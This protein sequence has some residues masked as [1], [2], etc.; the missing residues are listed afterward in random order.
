[1]S[2]LTTEQY[3]KQWMDLSSKI[4]PK[5]APEERERLLAQYRGARKRAEFEQWAMKQMEGEQSE[6]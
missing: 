3:M 4:N 6:G 1:M 2:R 5:P